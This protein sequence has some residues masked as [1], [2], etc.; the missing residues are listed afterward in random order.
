MSD[1]ENEAAHSMHGRID[2]KR[3]DEFRY[4]RSESVNSEDMDESILRLQHTSI[5]D[6]LL[7]EIYD[8]WHDVRHDSFESDTFTECSSTSDIFPW[9]KNSIQL[10]IE[11]K[12][13]GKL[14]RSTLELQSKHKL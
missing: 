11:T 7:F 1:S 2:F 8:R 13:S 4:S 14:N 12:H 10:D 6:D 9:R 3:R 5:V